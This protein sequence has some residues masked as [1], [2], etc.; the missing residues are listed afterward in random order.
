MQVEYKA[1]HSPSCCYYKEDLYVAF[2]A[3]EREC[4]RQRVFVFKKEKGKFSLFRALPPGSGNPV[5]MVLGD[6]LYCCYSRFTRPMTNDVFEL[7]QTCYTSV[8]RLSGA[9]KKQYV[10]STYCCPRC[11]PH[12]LPNGAV[13]LPC[14]DESVAKGI[15]FFISENALLERVFPIGH[16]KQVIQPS[17][18]MCG[19]AMMVLY[20][21]FTK[22]LSMRPDDEKFALYSR[23]FISPTCGIQFSQP[24]YSKIPNNNESVV[25]IN[26]KEENALVI[27]NA[28]SGRQDLTLGMASADSKGVLCS[29]NLLVLNDTVKASYPNCT[30]NNKNQLTVSFTAYDA[31]INMGSQ[32]CIATVSTNYGKVLS[33]K[34]IGPEDLNQLSLSEE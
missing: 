11:N 24:Q 4:I 14:Y 18:F 17:V 16:D 25:G 2:Y 3:G 29:E 33:R 15:F 34:Y 8:E 9:E 30:F 10:L 21:N 19:S 20:R 12:T 13:L 26:D 28:K 31:S 27:F 5:L 6:D 7:W 22:R 23:M 32:I 1:L